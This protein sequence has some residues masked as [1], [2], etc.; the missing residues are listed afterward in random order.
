MVWTDNS[1]DVT[2]GARDGLAAARNDDADYLLGASAIGLKVAEASDW[3]TGE[4]LNAKVALDK[5]AAGVG[6]LAGTNTWTADQLMSST[7]ELQFNHSG[8]YIRGGTLILTVNGSLS[9]EMKTAGASRAIFSNTGLSVSSMCK[10]ASLRA[11]GNAAG[12]ASTNTY[13]G[14]SV[15]ATGFPPLNVTVPPSG[16]PPNADGDA[17]LEVYRGTAKGYVLWHAA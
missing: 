14:N 16:G 6:W 4:P 10:A 3:I 5:L 9:V 7:N 17:W 15:A 1:D 11:T 2:D 8:N 12:V 13:S